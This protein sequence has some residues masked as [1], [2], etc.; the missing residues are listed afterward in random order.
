MTPVQYEELLTMIAPEI[1]KSC[2]TRECIGPSE[3]L[4]VT[5]RYL[6]TGDSQTTIGMNFRMSPTTVGRIIFSTCEALWKVL[7]LVFMKCP[8][9][10]AEWKCIAQGF[11]IKWNFPH[12][13][14]A[15]DGKHV[16]M[17]APAN[18][19]SMFFNYNIDIGDSGRNSDGGVFS[20]S[21]MGESI[22]KNSLGIPRP[23]AFPSTQ[24]CYPFVIVADEAFQLQ[25]NIM[26]PYPRQALGISERVFNYRLSRA[27]RVIENAFGIVAARFRVF[28]RPIH[29]R[30]EMVIQVTKAVI[31]LHNYLMAERSFRTAQNTVQLVSWTTTQKTEE[32]LE[33]GEK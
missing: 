19:G 27:R 1:Q 20:Y 21:T 24:K 9:N 30:V 4:C 17:Q 2:I 26:K 5:L 3:R 12:C 10:E 25:Q 7:S 31:A 22:K 11:E 29:A 18:S 23:E 33:N 6:T 32:S 13:I 14:G 8:S 16:V 28:R 15:L